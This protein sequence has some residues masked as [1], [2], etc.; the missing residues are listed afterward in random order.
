MILVLGSVGCARWGQPPEAPWVPEPAPDLGS[1]VAR[2]GS[3][4]IYAREV[5]AEMARSTSTPR[6]ALDELISLHLLAEKAHRAN[7]FRPDWVNQELRSALAERLI[8]RDILPQIQRDSVPDQLLRAIYQSAIDTYMHPRLV[9][10]GFL[11]AYTGRMKPGPR[12]ER[13]EAARALAAHVASLPIRG[14][15]DF[16][17]I[18]QDPAWQARKISYRRLI[19]GPDRPFSPKVGAEVVKLKAP[20]DTTP[21]IDD[22][23]GFFLATYAGEKPPTNV[24]FAEVREELRQRYYDR[25][26]AQRLDELTR[27]LAEGHR[28]ESHPQSLNQSAPGHGS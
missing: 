5:A 15:E 7:P 2:V 10:A 23:D 21:L 11:I 12:A 28:V 25:W 13:A 22:V 17:A 26:R 8:E 14:P 16:E 24:S 18:A 4:P 27:K 6:D 9:D 20:G 1:V 3:V 19:Q